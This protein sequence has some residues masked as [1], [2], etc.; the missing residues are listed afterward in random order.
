MAIR[1]L[2]RGGLFRSRVLV[3]AMRATQ[4]ACAPGASGPLS[5]PFRR[6][7]RREHCTSVAAVIPSRAP[8]P[9]I[10]RTMR[11]HPSCRAGSTGFSIAASPQS[12]R[13]HV[14]Q[15]ALDA[16]ACFAVGVKLRSSGALC[17]ERRFQGRN[18]SRVGVSPTRARCHAASPI[19]GTAR[20]RVTAAGDCSGSIAPGAGDPRKTEGVTTL[21][22]LCGRASTDR[23]TRSYSTKRQR[24]QTRRSTSILDEDM[25]L[26]GATAS[27]DSPQGESGHSLTPFALL[28]TSER[29]RRL[30][31]YRQPDLRLLGVAPR[32]RLSAERHPASP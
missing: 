25:G 12:R 31:P 32:H 19:T 6:L 2:P 30:W 4:E 9:G 10:S 17:P 18:G 29:L 7:S 15:S 20:R 28:F 26:A 5:L 14:A 21:A 16:H 8:P 22:L 13:F 24:D 11:H 23:W 3:R 1:S 27:P